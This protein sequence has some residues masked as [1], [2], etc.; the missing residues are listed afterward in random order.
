M[1]EVAEGI[2]LE[3]RRLRSGSG[4][5]RIGDGK[6][7]KRVI[8]IYSV[9]GISMEGEL[10]RGEV[11]DSERTVA[12]SFAIQFVKVRGEVWPASGMVS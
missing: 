2:E 12:A 9:P 4:R 10:E 8:P 3:R 6:S 1:E 7:W 5:E 11:R